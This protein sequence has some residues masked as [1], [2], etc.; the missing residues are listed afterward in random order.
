MKEAQNDPKKKCNIVKKSAAFKLTL[1]L[2]KKG[3]ITNRLC[4]H[5]SW[6][7]GHGYFE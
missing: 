7:G 1:F 2:H 5:K 3:Y 4:K 6:S